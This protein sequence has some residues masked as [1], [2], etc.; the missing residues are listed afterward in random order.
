MRIL[1]RQLRKEKY[2]YSSPKTTL[3]LIEQIQDIFSEKWYD[4]STNLSGQFTS[5]NEFYVTLKYSAVFTAYGSSQTTLKC[6]ITTLDN[7]VIVEVNVIPNPIMYV[8][9]IVPLIFGLIFIYSML[10]NSAEI[11]LVPLLITVILMTLIPY[12]VLFYG[13]A[14]KNRLRH[15]FSDILKLTKV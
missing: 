10:S 9:T 5:D 1:P 14:S 3:D 4:A 13:Q 2:F 7:K 11:A 6:K 15:K 8:W 12:A